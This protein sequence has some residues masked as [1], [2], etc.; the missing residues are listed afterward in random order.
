MNQ[1]AALTRLYTFHVKDHPDRGGVRRPGHAD[2]PR[3]ASGTCAACCTL[4]LLTALMATL[5]A[6]SW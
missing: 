2:A 1:H 6:T 4:L 3:R 5:M